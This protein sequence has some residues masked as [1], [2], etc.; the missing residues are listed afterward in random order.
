MLDFS[1]LSDEQLHAATVGALSDYRL[2]DP[3]GRLA[4]QVWGEVLACRAEWGCRGKPE[5]Y[6]R[7][8]AEV[9]AEN[10]NR[11]RVNRGKP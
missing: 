1:H 3:C 10:A 5:E 11:E 8:D 4:G 7:A 6:A 2:L 9:A